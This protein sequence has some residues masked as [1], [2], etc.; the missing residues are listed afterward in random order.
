MKKTHTRMALT[1]ALA[2][3]GMVLLVSVPHAQSAPKAASA[4]VKDATGKLIGVA[5]FRET[6]E[7]TRITLR[8]L[9]GLPPGKHGVHVHAKSSCADA[10]DATTGANVKFGG[11]GPHF[12]PLDT[13]N[14]G[15]PMVSEKEGHAGDIPNLEIKSNGLGTLE[16]TTKKLTVSDG[17]LSVK[18]GA[19]IIHAN[20]DNY[21]NEPPN[22]GSGARLA[23][24]V[25]RLEN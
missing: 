10:P 3:I 22:G 13:K 20:E 9:S 18:S 5:H 12:D 15:G 21:K 2:G 24:G 16:F 11:A 1:A 8:V 14:H 6:A 17:P 25:I 7:G 4:V 19:I 23:C